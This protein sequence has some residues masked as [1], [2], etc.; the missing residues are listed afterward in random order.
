LE[1]R[2]TSRLLLLAGLCAH[3]FFVPVSI[4]GMQIALGVAALGLLLSRTRPARTPL[5]FPLL[6]FVA[7][8]VVS[9]LISPYGP[10]SLA[11]AT[12]WRAAAGY[13]IVFEGVRQLEEDDVPR[14]LAFAALGLAL[15]AVVGL[16]QYRTGVDLVH[17]LHLRQEPTF[18][19]AP[20]V[21]GRYGAM[22]FF[23]SRLSFG[24]N[25]CVVLSLLGGALSQGALPRR[26]RAPVAVALGLGFVA[27]LLTFDRAGWLSLL[28]AALVLIAL[29][30]RARR[31]LLP[32]LAVAVL[33]AALTPGV[34][35][36]FQSSFDA[37]ANG[38]RVFIWQR[39]REII[40][41]HPL[42]GIGFA[43]YP[44]VCPAY[45]DRVDRSFPMRTWAHN[46][47]LDLLAELGPLGLL[48]LLWVILAAARALL[49]SRSKLAAGALAA[50][51]AL[52]VIAQAHDVFYDT[53]VMY[54]LWLSLSLGTAAPRA[55]PSATAGSAG[56]R[57]RSG[58]TTAAG[59]A[60]G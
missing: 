28:A 57:S 48:A 22:G 3:A 11:F 38:D 33:M 9:D 24:H 50:G 26:L 25:A 29:A 17:A 20:G 19:E 12:L 7:L 47:E 27:V 54:A 32:L 55:R 31:L 58:R 35:A 1:L 15:A 5:T 4:A 30:P 60:G 2:K 40:R 52:L 14:V 36:R 53:K 10:P 56:D 18:V 6:A 8:A 45:Y 42:T 23:T 41:D 37:H 13:F 49:R 39:A 16:V 44:R 51:V 34:R 43:N 46:S 59:A 21:P